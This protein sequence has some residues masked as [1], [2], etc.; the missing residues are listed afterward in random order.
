MSIE[1][2]DILWR[3][4]Q[5]KHSIL[6]VNDEY[7]L[8]DLYSFLQKFNSIESM[9]TNQLLLLIRF[10]RTLI[11]YVNIN[12]GAYYEEGEINTNLVIWFGYNK[13]CNVT[14][15]TFDKLKEGKGTSVELEDLIIFL[16]DC[17]KLIN[18][19]E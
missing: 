13:I 11:Y 3:S 2:N 8:Q 12:S 4:I 5:E 14:Y 1:E 6:G 9:S 19:K 16:A 10:V 15:S 18:L 7:L 17:Y